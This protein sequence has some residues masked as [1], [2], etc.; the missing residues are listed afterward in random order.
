MKKQNQ[1]IQDQEDGEG[2]GARKP[3]NRSSE[4]ENPVEG[5]AFRAELQKGCWSLSCIKE[6]TELL[7]L[8]DGLIY[9]TKPRDIVREVLPFSCRDNEEI[10][11]S[12][13]TLVSF[14]IEVERPQ[15]DSEVQAGSNSSSTTYQLQIRG[16]LFFFVLLLF[17]LLFVSG[18]SFFICEMTWPSHLPNNIG[19]GKVCQ[20][21][22]LN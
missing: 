20:F 14:L 15:K 17:L 4:A 9:S 11:M 22:R 3:Q 19:G 21:S 5:N 7:N 2:P 6:S 12:Q 10:R 1:F 8:S 13:V 16:K 18:L